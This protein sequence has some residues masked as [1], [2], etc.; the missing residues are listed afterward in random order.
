MD[1]YLRGLNDFIAAAVDSYWVTVQHVHSIYGELPIVKKIF[2]YWGYTPSAPFGPIEGPKVIPVEPGWDRTRWGGGPG[3]RGGVFISSDLLYY[4]WV[5][6]PVPGP[7]ILSL[8]LIIDIP[9]CR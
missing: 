4:F 2:T 6:G 8:A 5:W 3:T 9:G 7:L 1:F